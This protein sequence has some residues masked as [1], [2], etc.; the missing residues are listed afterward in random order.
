MIYSLDYL[1]GSSVPIFLHS[2]QCLSFLC[3]KLWEHL[4]M[5]V[6]KEKGEDETGFS[7]KL[8]YLEK[9]LS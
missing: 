8:V 4:K 5:R 9:K 6:V 2:L 3:I 1:F 7:W